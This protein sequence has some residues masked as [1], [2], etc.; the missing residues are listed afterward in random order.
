MVTETT[1]VENMSQD[2]RQLM[3]GVGTVGAYR[4]TTEKRDLFDP[5]FVSLPYNV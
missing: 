3:F 2:L 5:A 1:K 4:S